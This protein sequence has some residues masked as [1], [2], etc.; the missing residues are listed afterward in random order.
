MGAASVR[1][2]A[3]PQPGAR[4]RDGAG[5]LARPRY[6]IVPTAGIEDRLHPLPAGALVTVTCSA[7]YG[8]DRTLDV[9]DAVTRA[10][11]RAVPHIAARLVEDAAHLQAIVRRIEAWDERRIFVIAGDAVTPAGGYASAGQLLAELAG[12]DHG[13]TEIGVAG[14]PEG[15]PLIPDELLIAALLEKQAVAT[16]MVTQLCFAPSVVAD[17]TWR[18]R[19]HGV[20]LPLVVGVPGV[21][22]RRK[23]VEMSWKIGV[24][25]SL[26]YLTRQH[27]L[28]SHLTRLRRYQADDFLEDLGQ[29]LAEAGERIDG[30][31]L[32]T[33]N[34]LSPTE[35]WREAVVACWSQ[36]PRS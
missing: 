21:V 36:E 17:W 31:H 30:V 22:H 24:G 9:A 15:H 5:V 19:S 2:G 28:L 26:R 14:Y 32:F 8:L 7:R 33:F 3:L 16:H 20:R 27:G 25:D 35:Q 12:L 29:R 1:A 10:G 23:L 4:W 34:Q 13:I 18:M 6:E 11:L